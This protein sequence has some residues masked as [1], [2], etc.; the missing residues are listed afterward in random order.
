MT[1]VS[2]RD[3]ENQA[4]LKGKR[5]VRVFQPKAIRLGLSELVVYSYRAYQGEYQQ[6]PP[7]RK[8]V[9][10]ALGLS[11]DTILRCDRRLLDNG[12]LDCNLHP[13]E[14]APGL[15]TA[16]RTADPERHWRH[17]LSSWDLFIRSRD[18]GLSPLSVAVWS[19]IV[20]CVQTRFRPRVGLGASYL[21]SVVCARRQNIQAVLKMME[22]YDK[23]LVRR[24]GV[25]CPVL[26]DGKWLADKWD[27]TTNGDAA[28]SRW[29]ELP[30]GETPTV[31]TYTP[32]HAQ[33]MRVDGE[34]AVKDLTRWLRRC[35]T[36]LPGD[37]QDEILRSVVRTEKWVNDPEAIS[38]ELW[39]L[40]E[41]RPRQDG[42]RLVEGWLGANANSDTL[43]HP[44]TPLTQIQTPVD[45][46]PDTCGRIPRH[47][48]S[49]L[50]S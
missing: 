44:Q 22:C 40:V 13:V 19:F 35:K 31:P 14:P 16:K 21:S 27:G 25:W 30:D 2:N 10:R 15:F 37:R 32:C 9:A 43:T 45:A 17:S 28:Q 20:H 42:W 26:G 24:D 36:D 3:R 38:L 46:S 18:C 34:T 1:N 12:L 50:G 49:R 48:K 29:G 7:N 4:V 23:I 33:P 39:Q 41:D 6:Q 47:N 11:H 5:T 8:Q